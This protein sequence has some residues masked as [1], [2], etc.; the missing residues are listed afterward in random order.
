M[1]QEP[2]ATYYCNDGKSLV[3]VVAP[4][5]MTREEKQKVIDEWHQAFWAIW[6]SFTPDEQRQLNALI[7]CQTEAPEK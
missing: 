1:E 5:P 4:P 2:A 6:N 3:Q 7:G